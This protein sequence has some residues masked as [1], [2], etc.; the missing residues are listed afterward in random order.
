MDR[1]VAADA[2]IRAG[3]GVASLRALVAAGVGDNHVYRLTDSGLLVRLHHGVYG[4]A[5]WPR[6]AEFAA[7]AAQAAGSE[8]AVVDG[9]TA[10]RLRQIDVVRYYRDEELADE[11]CDPAVARRRIRPGLTIHPGPLPDFQE[12]DGLRAV[13]TSA[14]LLRLM[15]G[16]DRLRAVWAAEDAWRKRRLTPEDLAQLRAALPVSRRPWVDAV[17]PRSESPLETWVRLCA[18]DEEMEL[19]PQIEAEGYRMDLGIRA[20]RVGV[21]C[22]GKTAHPWE[23]EPVA[24]DRIRERVLRAAGWDIIRVRWADMA[25]R[26]QWVM[27]EIRRTAARR[28]RSA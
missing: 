5:G 15:R 23:D 24:A 7:R 13:A 12:V 4:L 19:E 17:D 3:H 27:A 2:A 20:A 16:D 1:F 8:Q 11:I 6:S 25:K 22:D 9:V 28:T 10:L 14:A 21:E 26:R 18:A